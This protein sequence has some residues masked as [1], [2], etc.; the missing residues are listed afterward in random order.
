MKMKMVP[1][2]VGAWPTRLEHEHVAL[3]S[4]LGAY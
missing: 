2:P 3:E 1:L 4:E